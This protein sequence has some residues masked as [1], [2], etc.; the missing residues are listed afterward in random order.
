MIYPFVI[1]DSDAKHRTLERERV[2]VILQLFVKASEWKLTAHRAHS[3][4][5]ETM[6]LLE[7]REKSFCVLVKF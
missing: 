3:L 2:D 4:P 6:V 5:R 1:R 7:I